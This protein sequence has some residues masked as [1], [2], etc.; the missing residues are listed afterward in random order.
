MQTFAGI[1]VCGSRLAQEIREVVAENASLQYITLI[2]HSMGGLILRHAAGQL[3]SPDTGLVAGL[4]PMHFIT[5]ATPHLGCDASGES[6][7]RARRQ[8]TC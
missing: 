4:Q 1:D 2:G 7:V 8:D 5:M 3:Y 6:Q